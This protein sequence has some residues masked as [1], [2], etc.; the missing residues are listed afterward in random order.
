VVVAR[1][2]V[3]PERSP[4]LITLPAKEED[5]HKGYGE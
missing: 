5:Q 4:W 2:P 3:D 1:E